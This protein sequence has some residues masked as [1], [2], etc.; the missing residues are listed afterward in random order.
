MPPK[1]SQKSKSGSN[2]KVTWAQAVR[3]MVNRSMSTGQLLP[4]GIFVLLAIAFWR[5]PAE[6][7]RETIHEIISGFVG[8]QLWGWGF[9]LVLLI[10]WV[11]HAKKMRKEFSD[12]ADRIGKEKTGLQQKQTPQKLGT[13]QRSEKELEGGTR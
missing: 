13:S 1:S 12:E 4:F 3:D 10:G 8:G 2:G 7:I 9:S 6:G 11:S 5:M